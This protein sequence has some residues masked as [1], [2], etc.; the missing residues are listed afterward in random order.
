MVQICN[1]LSRQFGLAILAWLRRA[2]FELLCTGNENV[3]LLLAALLRPFRKRPKVV[4]MNHHLSHKWK[5]RVFR[6][7]GLEVTTDAI[8]CLNEFQAT[9][10]LAKLLVDP[11]KILQVRYGACVD[12]SFFSPREL[13][14]PNPYVLSVGRE[15]RDYQTLVEALLSL[16]IAATIV[17]SGMRSPAEY[18]SPLPESD[19]QISVRAGL[20][21]LALRELYAGAAFVILP[22]HDVEYPAGITTIMEAMAMG[23]AVIA[24]RSRGI[25]EFIEDGET[26]LWANAG[27][28][29]DLREKI[30]YLWNNPVIAQRMGVTARAAI[31]ER[32]NLNRYVEEIASVFLN[33]G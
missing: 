10:A 3:G 27:D 16:D 19:N 18:P 6:G 8:I 22:L 4:T 26:G 13:Q 2:E 24:T 15:G 33:I 7:L 9:F 29:E 31:T 30:L 12:G 21:C 5:A 1:L 25:S 23:K 11:K 20:N 28:A 14:N 17:A 32:V